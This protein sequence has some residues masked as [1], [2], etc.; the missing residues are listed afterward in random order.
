MR[1]TVVTF[2]LALALGAP[3]FAGEL[4]PE[5]IASERDPLE[6]FNRK[7]FWFNDK[8]DVYVLEPIA[9]AWNFIMPRRVQTSISNFFGNLRFPIDTLNDTLQ[10]K[11]VDAGKDVAR[12]AINT[13]VGVLGF[14]DPATGWGFPASEEDFG[15][16]LAV[17][18]VPSGPYLVLPVLGASNPRDGV[19]LAVDYASSVVPW[20]VDAIPL[21]G[22]YA[23]RTANDRSQI[24]EEVRDVKQ[25]SLDYYV[26][27]RNGYVQRRRNLV[28]DR[29]TT[30]VH[31]ELYYPEVEEP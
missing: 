5:R 25:G 1:T 14:L 10:L 26:A 29:T 3:A 15:Q 27:V 2:V 11:P 19:G 6:G 21:W 12:F 7:I 4:E 17:W 16:T 18:R 8:A 30:E 31:E 9:R 28:Q 22:A 23:L 13:T 20:F 24:L